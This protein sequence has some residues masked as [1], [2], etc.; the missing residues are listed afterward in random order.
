[1]ADI[2]LASARRHRMFEP[3]APVLAMVSGGAD[4]VAMLRLLAGGLLGDVELAVLH[5]NHMLR[6]D[7]ADEDEAFVRDLCRELGVEFHL[8]RFDVGAY[9][10]EHSLNVEDAGRRVRYRFADEQ[11]DA[12]CER[13]GRRADSGRI[14]VAHNLDDR[15]ETFFMRAVSGSG[16]GGLGSI[17]P[18]RGRVVRPLLECERV[19]IRTWL[20][21]KGHSWREDPTNTDTAR[22]RAFVR[23]EL[24]PV[25]ERMNP[26]FRAG[27]A[28]TMDLLADDDR[29]LSVMA[30]AFVRDF[31]EVKEGVEVSF[32]RQW[33]A[34]LDR[35]MARR[36]IRMALS[37][38]FPEA[39]RLEAEHV[40]ALADGLAT[41]DFA[42]DIGFGLRAHGEYDTMVIAR[43]QTALPTVAPALLTLPGTAQLGAAG[44][45]RAQES[46]PSD[47]SGTMD[48]VVIDADA[49]LGE[50]VVDEVRGGDRMRPLGMKGSRKLSDLLIDAKV[51]KRR[52][53]AVPVVRDGDR[54]V[55]LA[56]VRMSED[57]RVT[58]STTAAFRLTWERGTGWK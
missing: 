48:S 50:L 56:G 16:S 4:S 13:L 34:T 54:I 32:N 47:T 27:L 11:L 52:R 20:A 40:D 21:E 31:A 1:M 53:G 29:L 19:G 36:V 44:V 41:D 15:V 35:T 10:Q 25:A 8:V 18:V 33:M 51:A 37:A 24:L 5:V 28:R 6:E 49:V 7:S 57:Y 42:R 38:A 23:A 45:L 12:M 39:S 30:E 3:S 22:A 58:G 26:A 43:S 2:A 46:P 14:A 9:A 17:A 55:W